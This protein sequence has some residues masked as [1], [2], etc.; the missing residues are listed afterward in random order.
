M[1]LDEVKHDEPKYFSNFPSTE[2]KDRTFLILLGAALVLPLTLLVGCYVKRIV[3]IP[4]ALPQ[5]SVSRQDL[6]PQRS[7]SRH[8][9][10]A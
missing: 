8:D 9:L 6:V 10:E 7:L 3:S 4:F 2:N 5:R 1:F